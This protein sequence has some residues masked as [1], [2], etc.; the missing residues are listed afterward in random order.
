VPHHP[1][2][3]HPAPRRRRVAAPPLAALTACVIAGVAPLAAQRQ[4]DAQIEG[5]RLVEQA[6]R[7][8]ERGDTAA[9]VDQAS[10]AA[11]IAPDLADARFL[12]G[13]LLARTSGAGFG[14]WG[15]R[16]DADREFEAALRLDADNPRYLIEIARLRLKQPLLRVQAER[17]FRR[18]LASAHKS[19]D[20]MATAEVE[21]EIGHIYLRRYQAVAHRRVII[22]PNR[23]FE[24]EAALRDPHY[25]RDILLDYSAAVP[26]L[27]EADLAKAE[28]HYRAATA[29]APA[30][31]TASRGLLAL[32]AETGRLEELLDEARRFVR[33]APTDG[34][35]QLFLGMGLWRAGRAAAADT[36][37]GRALAALPPADRAPLEDLAPILRAADA[38]RYR[39]LPDSLRR[40]FEELYWWSAEPLRLTAENEFR[41]EHLARVAHAELLFGAPDL[42]LRGWLTD[43]GQIFIRYGPPP[44]VATFPPNPYENTADP[45]A[46][47]MVTTVWFYP[48][49]NLRFVFSGPPTYNYQRLAVDFDAYAENA[50]FI[51]PVAYDNVPVARSLDSV[52]VQVAQLRPHGDTAGTDVLFF[53]GIPVRRMA[54]GVDLGAGDLET[55]LFVTD[56]GHRDR[57]AR[58][59]AETVRLAAEQQFEVRTETARLAAGRYLYRFEARLHAAERSARGMS[60]LTVEALDGPGLTLSD[61]IVA[62]RIALRDEGP[63]GRGLGDFFIDPNASLEFRRG[64]P[65][66]IYTEA[67]GLT[68]EDSAGTGPSVRFQV[69]VRLRVQDLERG[70]VAARLLGDLLDVVGVTAEGDDQV[71][72]QYAAQEPLEGRDR[73]PVFLAIDLTKAPAG[74]YAL[75][76]AVTDLATG[77]VAVRHREIRVVEGP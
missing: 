13:L 51:T 65:V 56:D 64:E 19:G 34:D 59:G 74:R 15:R 70:G 32:L 5:R 44:V 41:L 28:T 49:R 9:A 27:G 24:W 36:A 50:R 1:A 63:R 31:A 8:A 66:H 21:A 26:G 16:I 68:A 3:R 10:R 4:S 22:G 7:L 52:A 2:A 55:A 30:S 57:I 54:R 58:R 40:G 75:D 53:A 61:V 37:F 14:S 25:T 33:I 43:R 39:E 11:R 18:A 62:D 29:A 35:A 67:Y 72:L 38:V 6:M 69:A 42:R 60:R 17:L 76:L 46:T 71:M 47:G 20:P 12:Y 45:M 48:D 77:R 73:V 23:T